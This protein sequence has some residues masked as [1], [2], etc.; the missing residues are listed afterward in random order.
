MVQPNAD[1]S[2]EEGLARLE[3]L[4]GQLES[5]DLTLD[6]M[7]K[8]YEQG[9]SLIGVCNQLLEDAELRIKSLEDDGAL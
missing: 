7:L 5:A 1:V 4:L 8:L 2:F 3:A 9:Q 6:E